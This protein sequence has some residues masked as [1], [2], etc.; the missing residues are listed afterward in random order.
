M[1]PILLVAVLKTISLNKKDK[2]RYTL[3][4]WGKKTDDKTFYCTLCFSY[5]DCEARGINA[6]NQHVETK[7]LGTMPKASWTLY[8]SI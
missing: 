1:P 6:I 2:L 4:S 7:K 3:T 8:S 5:I